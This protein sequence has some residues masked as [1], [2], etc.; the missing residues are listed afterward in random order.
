MRKVFRVSIFLLIATFVEFAQSDRATI[1]GTVSDP[2]GAVVPGAAIEARNV[3]TK[4]TYTAGTSST[5]NFTMPELP[6]GN[7]ELTVTVSGFKRYVKQNVFL[8]VA[9]AVR[10]DVSLQVGATSDTVTV[11]DVAPIL[12]TESGELSH[13]V[14]TDRVNNLPVLPI[15]TGAGGMRNPYAITNL[16]PGASF[17]ADSAVRIN[18][19]PS[20]TY[21]L[22][23]EGQDAQTGIF[24]TNQSWTQPSV[25]AV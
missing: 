13:N 11:T 14:Q 16:L 5:G 7:Y 8:P 19:L 25:D 15:G 23:L 18:G 4:A 24:T 17:T 1:T 21:S 9:Q 22:R 6:T 3:D 20:N 12:K 2:A 10:I